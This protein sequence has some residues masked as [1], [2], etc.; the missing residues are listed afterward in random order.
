[1]STDVI[2]LSVVRELTA[3]RDL[4]L[5]S[6]RPFHL[7]ELNGMKSLTA[8]GRRDQCFTAPKHCG[9]QQSDSQIR[10][11]TAATSHLFRGICCSR[12]LKRS[13]RPKAL[14]APPGASL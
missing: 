2:N 10:R 6:E 12:Q 14:A 1:M 4:Y 13:H 7:S 3:L 8:H 11:G 9:R 5:D